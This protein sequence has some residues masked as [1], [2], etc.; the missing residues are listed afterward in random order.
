MDENE[1]NINI[2]NEYHEQFKQPQPL[3]SSASQT[4]KA[5]CNAEVFKSWYD[6]AI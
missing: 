2:E 5:W 3:K 6:A 4:F 1:K